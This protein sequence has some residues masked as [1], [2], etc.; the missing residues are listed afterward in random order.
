[1]QPELEGFT[2]E[3][4]AQLLDQNILEVTVFAFTEELPNVLIA[5]SSEGR[6]LKLKEMVL[7]WVEIDCVDS[8]WICETKG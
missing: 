3:V 8:T 1:M 4:G 7:R 6:D 5:E 2:R